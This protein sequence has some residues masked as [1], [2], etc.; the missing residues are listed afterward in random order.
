MPSIMCIYMG[1]E[2]TLSR[3]GDPQLLKTTEGKEDPEFAFCP[4]GTA[5]TGAQWWTDA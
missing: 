2:D 4:W 3:N 1:G 5:Y